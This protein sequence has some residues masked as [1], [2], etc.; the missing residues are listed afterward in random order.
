MKA[1]GA[2]F[3]VA[4]MGLFVVP[5]NAGPRQLLALAGEDG[6]IGH[7]RAQVGLLMVAAGLVVA[8][9]GAFAGGSRR[10]TAS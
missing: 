3:F 2:G 5:H 6:A 8:A 1:M 10:S 4:A 7:G 9:I